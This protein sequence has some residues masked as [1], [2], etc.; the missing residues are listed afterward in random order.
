MESVTLIPSGHKYVEKS[1]YRRIFSGWR[2]DA[3]GI[4]VCST[5]FL[6]YWLFVLLAIFFILFWITSDHFATR[7]AKG[8][9][10]ST[11]DLIK[12]IYNDENPPRVRCVGYK[13]QLELLADLKDGFFEPL[14]V[15]SSRWGQTI[16][17]RYRFG[18]L[19]KVLFIALFSVWFYFSRGM[20]IYMVFGILY[21][22]LFALELVSAVGFP[23]YYRVTPGRFDLLTTRFPGGKLQLVRSISL[24]QAEVRCLWDYGYAYIRPPGEKPE[25]IS[26]SGIKEEEQVDFVRKLLQGG[27]HQ[28]GSSKLACG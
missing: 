5:G 4:V 15:C 8:H 6:S 20:P 25:T 1:L 19:S 26:I 21:I 13:H 2:A 7:K 16:S 17:S 27:N 10:R 18:W 24:H 3:L 11:E 28:A 12:Y 22:I 9:R 23:V 14:V